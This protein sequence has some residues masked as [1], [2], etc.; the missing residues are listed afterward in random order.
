MT[1]ATRAGSHHIYYW[2]PLGR[3][4]P[5][6]GPLHRGPFFA[7]PGPAPLR[8]GQPGSERLDPGPQLDLPGPSA[9]VLAVEVEILLGDGVGVEQAVR[10]A[11]AGTR[12]ARLADTAVDDEM[13]D[14]DVLRRQFAGKALR[15]PAETEL[16]HGEGDRARI[17]LDARR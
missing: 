5:K 4:L 17:A 7:R 11:P 1:V 6:L 3:F 8:L 14:M 10:A 12:I 13:T 9:A 16:A 15:Q 2:T